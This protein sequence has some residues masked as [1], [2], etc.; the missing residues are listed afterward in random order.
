VETIFREHFGAVHLVTSTSC[1]R[2]PSTW[3][4]GGVLLAVLGKWSHSVTSSSGDDLGRWASASFSGCD[5]RILT[6]YLVYNCV[7]AR[8]TDVGPT[9]A[10]AQ[11]W[12][13]LR[14]AGVQEPK[15]RLQC[16]QDLSRDIHMRHRN[17]EDIVVVGDFNETLG[18][19]PT[20]MASV[21]AKHSLYDVVDHV[22]GPVADIP[23]YI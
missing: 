8:I 6:L 18:K 11:Q 9:T 17:D 7:D 20:L 22:H 13:L 3:K 16:V 2:S 23:I 21:C 12:Q 10:F 4:P 14:L 19:D 1:I 15:P 5:G